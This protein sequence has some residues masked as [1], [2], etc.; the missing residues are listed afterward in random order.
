MFARARNLA[1]TGMNVKDIAHTVHT[2]A[3]TVVSFGANVIGSE[4]RGSYNASKSIA[5]SARNMTRRA[6]GTLTDQ[7]KYDDEL[8]AKLNELSTLNINQEEFIAWM[9]STPEFINFKAR[10]G[11]TPLILA[12]KFKHEDIINYI[13]NL[14][15]PPGYV[16]LQDDYGNTALM[17]AC[18]FGDFRTVKILREKN[19]SFYLKYKDG[20]TA[21]TLACKFKHEDIINY[22]LDL[23]DIL[24]E[25]VNLYTNDGN[26]AL[27]LACWIGDVSI[28][29]KMLLK[30]AEVNAQNR[31][32]N[33]PLIIASFKGYLDIVQLLLVNGANPTIKNAQGKT[34]LMLAKQKNLSEI[35]G[36]LTLPVQIPS[37]GGRKRKHTR[38][39]KRK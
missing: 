10:N 31:Y 39:R 24:P 17:F 25:Y 37:R 35:I 22:I 15:I 18:E 26:T 28:V 13:L 3:K 5:S 6:L 21:L 8:K 12:C 1:P 29:K 14:D 16:D 34:A 7:E 38:K 20:Y 23:D 19:A 30:G 33:T 9:K 32:D 27:I 11:S 2:G 4:L 36:A